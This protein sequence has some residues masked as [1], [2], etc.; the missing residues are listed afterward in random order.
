MF[1][2]EACAFA[3]ETWPEVTTCKN[4]RV[5]GFA[6]H[7]PLQ[8]ALA[9][10]IGIERI[11]PNMGRPGHIPEKHAARGTA[12]RPRLPSL[13]VLVRIVWEWRG[14]DCARR[15]TAAG[16]HDCDSAPCALG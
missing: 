6:N 8:H 16:L 10:R 3:D 11:S 13:R 5:A 4:Y 2:G 9:I 7:W 15:Q 1:Q 12:G 14:V